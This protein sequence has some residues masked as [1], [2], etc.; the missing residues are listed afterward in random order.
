MS[1][2]LICRLIFKTKKPKLFIA[3]G[4][5]RFSICLSF[6]YTPLCPLSRLVLSP[7]DSGIEG[8]EEKECVN[9]R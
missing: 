4:F 2:V 5:V 3:Q 7:A 6:S 9:L 1:K 8:G